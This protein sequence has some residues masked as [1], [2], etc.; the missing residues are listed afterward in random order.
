MDAP[1]DL[2][3]RQLLS[4]DKVVF[5]SNNRLVIGEFSHITPTGM[6][7]I[8][9]TRERWRVRDQAYTKWGVVRLN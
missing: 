5:A 1:K 3:G 7:A 6:F 8:N 9:I 2:T 4:G